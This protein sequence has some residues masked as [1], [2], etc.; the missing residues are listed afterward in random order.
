MALRM[1]SPAVRV[2]AVS[3]LYES[4]PE[5][6][7]DQP[8]YY[9]AACSVVTELTPE[10][11]LAQVKRVE[12]AIGRRPAARWAARPIDID[13]ALY[14]DLVMESAA[15]TIPHPR[16]EGRAFV[17]RPLLDLDGGLVNPATGRSL[18]ALPAARVEL[19]LVADGEWWR[20]AR[21]VGVRADSP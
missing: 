18:G 12:Q 17:V 19:A 16:L 11:L 8:S 15:L 21:A 4:P 10:L 14:D 9:N 6:G 3:R 1:L 13:I 2:E 7:S 20:D 5:D